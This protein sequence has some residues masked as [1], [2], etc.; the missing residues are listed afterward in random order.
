[1]KHTEHAIARV[2]FETVLERRERV[3]SVQD[4]ISRF[5][6]RVLQE[7]LTEGLSRFDGSRR[8]SVFRRV[9]LDLGEISLEHLELDLEEGITRQL[10]AWAMRKAP[11]PHPE[12]SGMRALLG[13]GSPQ[14]A[15]FEPASESWQRGE[16]ESPSWLPPED[17]G[18]GVLDIAGDIIGGIAGSGNDAN[19]NPEQRAEDQQRWWM[20]LRNRSALRARLAAKLVPQQRTA[21]LEAWMPGHSAAVLEFATLLSRLHIDLSLVPVGRA[22]FES[23]L[24]RCILDEAADYRLASF[25]LSAFFRRVV[26]RLAHYHSLP[27]GDMASQIAAEWKRRP[28]STVPSRVLFPILDAFSIFEECDARDRSGET[29]AAFPDAALRN[30]FREAATAASSAPEPWARFDRSAP[31]SLGNLARFLEWGVLPWSGPSARGESVESEMLSSLASAADQVCAMVRSLG[32][33][34]PVRKRIAVQFSETVVERLIGELDPVNATWMLQCTKQLRMLNR[35]KPLFAIEDRA[36]GQLLS[37][38]TLEYLSERHWHALDEVSF[39]RFLLRRLAYRQKVGYE[40]LLADLALRRS[41][42]SSQS[43]PAGEIDPQ[44]RLSATIVT[45]LDTDL[46]GIRNRLAHAPRFAVRTEFRH[47]YCDLDVLAYWIRW[48]KLPEWSVDDRPRDV[49][50]SLEP[51]LDL[52]PPDCASEARIGEDRSSSEDLPVEIQPRA[53]E[54]LTPAL[55]IERWLL[56]GLWPAEIEAPEDLSLHRW[57]QNQSDAD[58]LHGLERCGAQDQVIRRM[59]RLS[60]ESVLRIAG[61]LSGPNAETVH[62]FLLAL[63]AIG[64]PLEGSF[65]PPW[66]E[67]VNRYALAGLLKDAP[68]E[69]RSSAFPLHLA[70]TTLLALSLSLQIPYER[71][72]LLLRQECDGPS[73]LKSLC[74]SLADELER[75]QMPATSGLELDSGTAEAGEAGI[76]LAEIEN[77]EIAKIYLLSGRLP[78]DAASL[79]FAACQRIARRITGSELASIAEACGGAGQ[80][81]EI[82]GRAERLLAPERFLQLKQLSSHQDRVQPEE[83]AGGSA[84]QRESQIERTGWKAQPEDE[85]TYGRPQSERWANPESGA[86]PRPRYTE[87]KSSPIGRDGRSEEKERLLVRLDALAFFL[88]SGA[89]PWWGDEELSGPC[90]EW[91]EPLLKEAP[92][93]FLRTLRSVASSP[94]AI[95][96][97]LRYVPRERIAEVIHHAESGMDGMMVQYLQAGEELANDA[98][99]TAAQRSSAAA[100]HWRSAL[101]LI[102]DA[103]QPRRSFAGTLQYLSGRVSQQMSMTAGRYWESLASIAQ[104]RAEDGSGQAAL[105]GILLQLKKIDAS[106]EA[107]TGSSR[108]RF[109]AQ[110][111]SR[112]SPVDG[113]R[114]PPYSVPHVDG[115]APQNEKA[116]AGA[117]A[118]LHPS[119]GEEARNLFV[120]GTLDAPTMAT[121]GDEAG[122]EPV[123]GDGSAPTKVHRRPLDETSAGATKNQDRAKGPDDRTEEQAPIVPDPNTEAGRLEYLLRFGALPESSP[124]GSLGKFMRS[125]AEGIGRNP[126]QYRKLIERSVRGALERRRMAKYF[127]AEALETVWKLLLPTDHAAA[128]LCME[129]LAEAAC[130]ASA[131]NRREEFRLICCEE[132]I[133]ASMLASGKEWEISSYLSRALLRLSADHGLGTT[134]AVRDLRSRFSRQPEPLRTRLNKALERAERETARIPMRHRL[135]VPP[136]PIAP[137][138]ERRP[139]KQTSQLPAG[140]PFYIANAGAIILWPFLGRYFQTL[141][142]MEKNAFRDAL[143]RSRAIYLVQYLVTG[144]AEAPEPALLLNKILCGTPPE[145]P[146]ESPTTVS[147]EEVAL[148]TQLLQGV[149]ANWGKLG[150]TSIEALRES[151]LIR[152]GRLL[153]NESDNSWALTV[154]VKGYDML[155]DALPWRLSMIRLPWMQ[156]LLNVK[157][158]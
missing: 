80:D 132:L 74:V 81:G 78:A 22:T 109:S 76:D 155:L 126:E 152:E 156:T 29:A 70:H 105:A 119:P 13:S 27:Y 145:Q 23:Q 37:E 148:S 138:T 10:R 73:S 86:N 9:E 98:G 33:M 97:L 91:F 157:W 72:L 11:W 45:L 52:L 144:V 140:E 116:V 19:R 18:G 67:H 84:T 82:L 62:D 28:E 30:E 107:E 71:L 56:F 120:A 46:L 118:P 139:P 110:D 2:E 124:S 39:L 113:N 63:Y 17:T 40:V 92:E 35:Q 128:G 24:W 130:S 111:G 68:E 55:Q 99:L 58:W 69:R 1:M 64:R 150:N 12:E 85:Q 38:L 66:Q 104:V 59:A 34:A 51:L 135:P 60:P 101:E 14:E 61:L 8:T 95:E 42:D 93:D 133:E 65:P 129:E 31:G 154:S 88:R 146:M 141:G 43:H 122:L 25:S 149:I 5:A 100:A 136:S 36:F 16:G 131:A 114:L 112:T 94:C 20:T 153:R 147:E 108:D 102:L 142:L 49:V 117:S 90:G 151:F 57:L 106:G 32:E 115:S 75:W 121:H 83:R 50:E 48:R 123:L 7:V 96:R 41:P 21:V 53:V 3:R 15:G 125:V 127:P 54:N 158:R 77:S 47:L 87:I 89:I 4:R 137:G 6:N 143:A 44:S 103:H 134:E 26:A 79:S